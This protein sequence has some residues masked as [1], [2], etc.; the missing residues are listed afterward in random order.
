M[1]SA[2]PSAGTQPHSGNQGLIIR[3]ITQA[4]TLPFLLLVVLFFPAGTVNWPMAWAFLILYLGGM[5][6]INLWLAARHPGLARERLIIPRASEKWDLRL[7]GFVNFLLLAILFPL[8][9]WDHRYGWSPAIPLSAS[10]TALLLFAAMFGFMAWSMSVNG[11]FSSAVRL[12]SDRGQSVATEGPYR[13][14]RHPGYLAM[15]LQFLA[16]PVTLGSLWALIP[17]FAIGAVYVY[18]TLLEDKFLLEKLPGYAEY[19]DRVR[20]RLIPGV[21]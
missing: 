5:L 3:A 15:I 21:W 9:G 19:A 14:L 11:F 12:Q 17:A 2:Q 7:I 16:I 4:I 10:I 6:F 20:F 8:S 1:A 18:R 13:R